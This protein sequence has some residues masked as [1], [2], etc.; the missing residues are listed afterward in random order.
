MIRIWKNHKKFG[1][2]VN[3]I[4]EILFRKWCLHFSIFKKFNYILHVFIFL[5]SPVRSQF[6]RYVYKSYIIVYFSL[7]TVLKLFLIFLFFDFF[8]Y[9]KMLLNVFTQNLAKWILFPF[10]ICFNLFYY[11][12]IYLVLFIYLLTY[13]MFLLF[14]KHLALSLSLIFKINKL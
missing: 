12:F 2:F 7:F 13:L 4:F 3:Y 6:Y 5:L 14:Y 8:F 11:Y 9:L 1:L 10:Y